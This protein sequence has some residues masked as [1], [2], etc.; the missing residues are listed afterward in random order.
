MLYYTNKRYD[1][2]TEGSRGKKSSYLV[3]PYG[4]PVIAVRVELSS[5]SKVAPRA[6]SRPC[7]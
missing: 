3:E 7:I 6:N 1:P 2:L 5:K 4:W